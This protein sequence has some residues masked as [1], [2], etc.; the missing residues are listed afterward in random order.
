MSSKKSTNLNLP[1]IPLS[2]SS[3]TKSR[4]FS[5]SNKKSMFFSATKT[6]DKNR[7]E[8]SNNLH[9]SEMSPSTS[10]FIIPSSRNPLSTRDTQAQSNSKQKVNSTKTLFRLKIK[11]ERARRG[12]KQLLRHP[13]CTIHCGIFRAI[14]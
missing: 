13:P 5:I 8:L 2:P 9:Q 11:R 3:N 4:N 12:K 7:S 6:F 1:V 10:R 14:G